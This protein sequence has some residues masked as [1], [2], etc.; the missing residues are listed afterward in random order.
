MITNSKTK[1]NQNFPKLRVY[2]KARANKLLVTCFW[3]FFGFIFIG[4]FVL[5]NTIITNTGTSTF[6]SSIDLGDNNIT[7]AN[8]FFGNTNGTFNETAPNRPFVSNAPRTITVNAGGG[9]DYLTI[10]EAVNQVPY[11]LR[12]KYIINVA[13]G[14]YEED[15]YVPPMT[16]SGINGNEGSVIML[17]IV[18]NSMVNTRVK[19]FQ[20][21]SH[22]G[23]WAT[24]L[25]KFN[26]YGT[27]PTSDEGVSVSIYGSNSVLLNRLNMT[28]KSVN[29][30]IMFYSSAGGATK[31][32]FDGTK[33]GFAIKGVSQV[34]L[35]DYYNDHWLTGSVDGALVNSGKGSI[36]HIQNNQVTVGGDIA[37]GYGIVSQKSNITNENTYYNFDNFYGD[38]NIENLISNAIYEVSSEGLIFA[39]NFNSESIS[40]NSILDS[41]MHKNHLTNIGAKYNNS[42]GFNDGSSY[43]YNGSG[44]Y[45]TIGKPLFTD[46]GSDFTICSWFKPTGLTGSVVSRIFGSNQETRSGSLYIKSQ[47]VEGSYVNGSDIN[48]PSSGT[49]VLSTA[50]WYF[51][52]YTK[53]STTG[54]VYLDGK[55]DSV[56]TEIIG[57]SDVD[58]AHTVIGVKDTG[59]GTP[60]YFVG[61]IDDVY[62][63][64]RSLSADE[65]NTLYFGR[66]EVKSSYVYQKD[67]QVDS[68]GNV[69]IT[70]GNLTLTDKI[71]FRLG[72][73]IDN[74]VDGW[75]R[76]TA[77]LK[78]TGM[79]QTEMNTTAMICN[80]ANAGG[81]YYNND[82]NKHYGCNV[83]GWQ[84]LY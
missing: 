68:S 37:S 40:G 12:H 70:S 75:I 45:M 59:S 4:G 38:V 62:I 56:P 2:Q 73:I 30:P 3:I 54:L 61:N 11:I 53:N 52:C 60:G 9:A 18:G 48:F 6:G 1:A 8:M 16:V 58:V 17:D 43:Y 20:V 49:T 24:H 57:D 44:S 71:T 36:A 82:T 79:I 74:L 35:G 39:S 63:Y 77:H 29:Y 34:Y 51:A 72:E 69:N 13:D 65:I 46:G 42:F 19:S 14:T 22:I 67:I 41:S 47:K 76:I 50:N 23:T 64:N 32:H 31:I 21:T 80:E 28:N 26:V 15:V 66:T 5:A 83:T 27:E 84:T 78:V 55:L 33:N 7:V 81:I 10:Q 25:R